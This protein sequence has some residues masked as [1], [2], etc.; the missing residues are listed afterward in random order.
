[1]LLFSRIVLFGRQVIRGTCAACGVS[2]RFLTSPL[3]VFFYNSTKY[4]L[5]YGP[6]HYLHEVFPQRSK[7]RC[8]ARKLPEQ[9][10]CLNAYARM[11]IAWCQQIAKSDDEA[12]LVFSSAHAGP[13]QVCFGSSA[14]RRVDLFIVAPGGIWKIHQYHESSAHKNVG[15][16][17]TCPKYEGV[18]NTYDRDTVQSDEFNKA[19][20]DYLTEHTHLKVSYEV[21][22]ECGYKHV[23]PN[24]LD[25][26]DGNKD[27]VLMP[28][29]LRKQETF[30]EEELLR[31]ILQKD[32]PVGGFVVLEG[33]REEIDDACSRTTGFCL[34]RSRPTPEELGPQALKAV[35]QNCPASVV[36]KRA[37]AKKRLEEKCKQPVTMLRKSFSPGLH[38][39]SMR[40]FVFLYKERRLRGFKIRGVMHIEER[41]Y[42]REFVEYCLQ[43]RHD[44]GRAGL[45]GSLEC[46]V[47]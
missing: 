45:K 28:R 15:H 5:P 24:L 42:L 13:G 31:L 17:E 4:P 19:Y 14:H 26:M 44:I 22:S 9:E 3:F 21:H 29:W 33:G 25:K 41:D 18:A 23:S 11:E 47:N 7:N 30:T 8:F 6:S 34:Q 27:Y 40:H 39:L 16:D 38:Y 46:M 12:S 1:M 35:L 32:S 43:K 37:W 20:A 10:K 2:P 36:D